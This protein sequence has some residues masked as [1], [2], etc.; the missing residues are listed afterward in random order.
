MNEQAKCPRCGCF[1]YANKKNAFSHTLAYAYTAGIFLI[2]A[3]LYPFLT[4]KAKGHEQVITLLEAVFELYEY[5][6]ILLA[7]YILMFIIVVPAAILL[8]IIMVMTPIVALG[9]VVKGS[10]FLGRLFTDIKPW[11][12]AQVFL[13]GVLVT[14][15]KIASLATVVMGVSFW[16]YVGFTIFITLSLST[17]DSHEFWETIE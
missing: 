7:S 9:K 1:L 14:M 12:M 5:G 8:C 6:S 3:N 16:A 4:F 17:L 13:I 2:F 10:K 11:N 15:I